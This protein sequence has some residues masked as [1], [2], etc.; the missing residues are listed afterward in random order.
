MTT[1]RRGSIRIVAGA[2]RGRRLK[3]PV[4][5]EVRPTAERV[6]EAVFDALGALGG[7]VV[8][9]LFAGSGAMGLEAMSRGAGECVFVE[10]DPKVGAVLR[11][12][13]AALAYEPLSRVMLSDYMSAVKRLIEEGKAFNLLFVDPPYRMLEEV[14][15]ALGP[16]LPALL[17]DGGVVVI[18]GP[19]AMTIAPGL[20]PV[21]DRIYADTRVVMIRTRRDGR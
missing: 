5:G 9:D 17:V 18:E 19:R 4:S 1:P 2:K 3:V 21:F 10:S 7:L 20:I 11:A 8:L 6:R 14:N 15:A 13:I 12:N 16:L